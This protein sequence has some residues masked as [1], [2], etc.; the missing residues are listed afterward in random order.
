MA[1]IGC[2]RG[3]HYEC[4]QQPCCCKNENPT[5]GTFNLLGDAIEEVNIEIPKQRKLKDDDEL[6]I[7][8][9]R[10]RAAAKFA[11]NPD[12]PCEW[13]GL[14]NCGGG[15]FTIV[16]C[17]DGKQEH[18]H[19][20]PDKKT[21]NNEDINVHLICSS[22]HNRWHGKNDKHYDR[23]VYQLMPHSPRPA[24]TEEILFREVN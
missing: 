8:G 6:S 5:G 22:C 24:T 13:K 17:L 4:S 3:L 15:K 12:E 23:S 19:H 9:G 11:I 7:S 20:G 21:S 2:G 1:C 14:S 16:G 18:R 10:K